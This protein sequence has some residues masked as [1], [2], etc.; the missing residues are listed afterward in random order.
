MNYFSFHIGDFRS[1]TGHLSNGEELVYRRLLDMYYDTEKPI[2]TDTQ[3]VSRRLRVET[4]IVD[5]VLADF[6][7]KC[8]DGWRNERCDFEITEYHKKAEISRVNGRFGGRP[9]GK[10]NNPAGTQQVTGRMLLATQWQPASKAT[11]NQ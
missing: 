6:F 10:T 8:E 7:K 4:K 5:A 2:P 9:K 11:N 1:A 3:W